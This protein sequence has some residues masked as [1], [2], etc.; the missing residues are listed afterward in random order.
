MPPNV[1]INL[2]LKDG[3]TKDPKR[4]GL[5]CPICSGADRIYRQMMLRFLPLILLALLSVGCTAKFSVQCESVPVPALV[6][7]NKAYVGQ[8]PCSIEIEGNHDRTF[9]GGA[10]PWFYDHF[11]AEPVEPAPGL[12]PQ[13]IAF[14]RSGT[15]VPGERIPEKILFDLRKLPVEG[16]TNAAA[17]MS[18]QR[19]TNQNAL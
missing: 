18:P 2:A 5:Y 9:N 13:D 16:A 11:T 1:Q 15:L 3:W 4:F 10:L 19:G 6:Y 17:A 12:Y 14:R 8:T 7:F